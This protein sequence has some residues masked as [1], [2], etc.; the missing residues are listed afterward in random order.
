MFCL[1]FRRH[2]PGIRIFQDLR[3]RK[4]FFFLIQ[5]LGV[6]EKCIGCVLV[7]PFLGGFLLKVQKRC[8]YVNMLFFGIDTF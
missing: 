7:Y 5:I 2:F 8:V 1:R 6:I 4:I 3:F